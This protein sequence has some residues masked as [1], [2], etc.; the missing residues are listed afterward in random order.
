[1]SA[2]ERRS[3]RPHLQSTAT[4]VVELEPLVSLQGVSKIYVSGDSSQLAVD[5]VDLSVRKGDFLSIIGPSGCGKTTLLQM[6]AGFVRPT[7]GRVTYRGHEVS[8]PGPDRMVVFQEYGLFPWMTVADNVAFGLEARGLDR[9]NR[10]RSAKKYIELVQ[11][12]GFEDRYPHQISGGM[13][14]RVGIARALALEPSI[15]LM[16]EPFG[17]LDSLTRDVLQEEILRI[18]E[19]TGQTF[20][21]ITHN[22]DEAVLLSDT[23][24]VMS[25]RPGRVKELVS[26]DL[27]KPRSV[28]MRLHDA[29]FAQY[30][31]HLT[32]ILRDEARQA[33]Q[34]PS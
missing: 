19:A 14:Q 31:E 11:L 17:A 18:R 7:E 16:D 20:I 5:C 24:L 34:S 13:K 12:S 27:P 4:K 10:K 23:V 29:R 21:L 26:I 30:R 2:A 1:M 3:E 15:V 28:D 22:I 6:V 32:A 33:M 25:F 8:C 9:E